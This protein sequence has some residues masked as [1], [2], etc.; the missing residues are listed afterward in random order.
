MGDRHALEQAAV[1]LLDLANGM[2]QEALDFLDRPR[3]HAF[4]GQCGQ[5]RLD[6]QHELP[7]AIEIRPHPFRA[8]APGRPFP[9]PQIA[10]TRAPTHEITVECPDTP[11]DSTNGAAILDL[12]GDPRL[13]PIRKTV[14][15]DRQHLFGLGIQFG[16]EIRN[17][18]QG[19]LIETCFK[20]G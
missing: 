3:R 6:A 17:F 10:V 8:G 1:D 5:A 19:N 14:T 18:R 7:A 11:H 12:E 15:A 16:I 9:D 4:R 20:T 13:S 2:R